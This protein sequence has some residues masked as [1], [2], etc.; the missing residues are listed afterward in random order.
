MIIIIA[1]NKMIYHALFESEAK[2]FMQISELP[3]ASNLARSRCYYWSF[4][5]DHEKY[6]DL[7][8]LGHLI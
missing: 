4:T 7:Y 8:R 6:K 2:R 3:I 5:E 1:T